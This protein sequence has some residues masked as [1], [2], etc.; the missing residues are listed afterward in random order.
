MAPD[1]TRFS[2]L[3]NYHQGRDCNIIMDP[4][5]VLLPS[6]LARCAA[7]WPGPNWSL[8]LMPPLQ[9]LHIIK[10]ERREKTNTEQTAGSGSEAT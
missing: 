2:V 10:E 9:S 1:K 4:G 3:F 7:A 8:L 6:Q 5:S